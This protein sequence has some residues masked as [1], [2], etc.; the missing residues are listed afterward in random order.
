MIKTQLLIN[1]QSNKYVVFFEC[2]LIKY[3]FKNSMLFL[4]IHVTFLLIKM[5][6][7]IFIITLSI[8]LAF[9]IKIKFYLKLIFKRAS[10]RGFEIILFR[11]YN[12]ESNVS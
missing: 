1:F 7:S 12:I 11:R 3:N 2:T 8:K 10:C 4:S 5:Y 9:L 6:N